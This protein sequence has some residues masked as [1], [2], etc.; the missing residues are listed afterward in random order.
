MERK[1]LGAQNISRMCMVCGRDNPFSLK[2]RFYE[3]DDGELLGVFEPMDIHQSYPGRVH[4]GVLSA[5][6]DE[7]IGRAV[8]LEDMDAWGVTVELTVRFRKPVPL[9]EEVRVLA[10][11]T[12]D[13]RRLFEGSGEIVLQDGTV[14]AEATGRYMKLGIDR[15]AEGDFTQEWFADERD[16]PASV[17]L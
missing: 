14:A 5:M 1:V 10:R 17:G 6:L 8:N 7:T 12:K 3:L 13:S 4:G 2:A 9:G 15:I 11:I 16:A